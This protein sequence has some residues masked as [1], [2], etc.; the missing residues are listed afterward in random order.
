MSITKSGHDA[1]KY[2]GVDLRP[3]ITGA[4]AIFQNI[5]PYD[6]DWKSGMSQKLLDPKE[7]H[8]PGPSRVT[9][10]PVV[11]LTYVP[12]SLLP[13]KYA[14][15]LWVLIEWALIFIS[16]FL[17]SNTIK[18]ENFKF[19]FSTIA[20]FFFCNSWF[21]RLHLERGQYYI[22]LVFLI[23]VLLH[24]SNKERKNSLL[25]GIIIGLIS[26]MRITF[27][28]SIFFLLLFKKVKTAFGAFLSFCLLVLVTSVLFGPNI[29][30]AYLGNIEKWEKMKTDS[31][32][33][34]KFEYKIGYPRYAEGFDLRSFLPR[35]SLNETFW[36]R[37]K[38]DFGYDYNYDNN[39]F[40]ILS[41]ISLVS[42]VIIKYQ[43]I[44]NLNL[45]WLIILSSVI[46]MEFFG[47]ERHVYTNIIFL[48]LVALFFNINFKNYH[49]VILLLSFSI[50]HSLIPEINI[51]YQTW[52]KHILLFSTLT[53]LIY[54]QLKN[55]KY[56]K[57][58]TR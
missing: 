29:W 38:N 54:S 50:G 57:K 48:P 41:I 8:P 28:P 47:P 6:I 15:I 3:K 37:V 20:V 18:K 32:Y 12:I 27:I 4:R 51:V 58:L 26:A 7:G 34:E 42:L 22:V 16:I 9:Y 45:M 55:L 44:D 14:R 21:W 46:F 43:S 53:L 19:Y 2:N 56:E 25:I 17:L 10:S 23:S 52:L 1:F 35:N 24:L 49:L 13:Y 33:S 11:L 31:T 30:P 39:R 40:I 5:N 36:T